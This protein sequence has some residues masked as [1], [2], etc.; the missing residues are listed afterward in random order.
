MEIFRRAEELH[1]NQLK[2]QEQLVMLAMT[3]GPQKHVEWR[4]Q[5]TLCYHRLAEI[6]LHGLRLTWQGRQVM[7]RRHGLPTVVG[8]GPSQSEPMYL[9]S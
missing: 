9:E 5:R 8:Q 6:T 3:G 7:A 2:M 1:W 4:V